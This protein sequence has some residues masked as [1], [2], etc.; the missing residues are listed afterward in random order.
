VVRKGNEEAAEEGEEETERTGE[1]RR[2]VGLTESRGLEFPRT[3][4]RYLVG[5]EGREAKKDVKEEREERNRQPSIIRLGQ[6]EKL[7]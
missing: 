6:E 7:T 5:V 2:G 4:R 3:H 1:G